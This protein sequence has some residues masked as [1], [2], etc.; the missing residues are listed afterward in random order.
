MRVCVTGKRGQV[1]AC[2]LER[3]APVGVEVVACGRPELDLARPDSIAPALEGVRPDVVVNAA[4]VTAVDEAEGDPAGTHLVNAEG[5]GHVASAAKRLGLPV[6]QISTDYVFDGQAGRPYLED[7]TPRPLSVYG[8]SKLEGERLVA[9]ANPRHLILRTAWVYSPFG[10][11]FLTFMLATA[12]AR[13]VIEVASVQRGSPTSGLDLA[14]AIL[15]LAKQL[16]SNTPYH[17][18]FHFAG[19]G[20]T[21]R[22][23]QVRF[24]L[25][26]SRQLGGPF[27]DV[28]EPTDAPPERAP[29]PRD[30]SLCSTKFSRTFNWPIP[31]WRESTEAAVARQLAG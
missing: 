7:D 21:T 20:S 2:L 16:C 31:E 28:C 26:T 19:G 11:N 1:V 22:G 24:I 29:R 25:E 15:R 27:A 10:R 8:R 4:A 30:S 23:G 17:G 13:K 12:R 6:V 5:A 14:D 18:V 9:L 3:A